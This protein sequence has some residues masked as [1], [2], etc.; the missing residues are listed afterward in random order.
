[1]TDTLLTEGIAAFQRSFDS[2]LAGLARKT[3]SLVASG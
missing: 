3:A 1:V 2:L